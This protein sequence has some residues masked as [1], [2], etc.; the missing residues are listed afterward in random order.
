M[1]KKLEIVSD[2]TPK[3][4][5]IKINDEVVSVT[6]IVF[7]VAVDDIVATLQIEPTFDIKEGSEND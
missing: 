7:A 5:T 2:G 1:V 3:G 6:S 4:T